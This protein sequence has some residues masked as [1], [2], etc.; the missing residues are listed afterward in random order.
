MGF[1]WCSFSEVIRGVGLLVV[2]YFGVSFT[3]VNNFSHG[4]PNKLG[5]ITTSLDGI[6]SL[7][8]YW[9]PLWVM[10]DHISLGKVPL[11]V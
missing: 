2:L 10:L 5:F 6:I 11:S 1:Q 9:Y 3:A 7:I 4:E 8:C